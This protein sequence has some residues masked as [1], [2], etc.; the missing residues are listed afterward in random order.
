MS[1][2]I[3]EAKSGTVLAEGEEGA[4]V[5]SLRGQSLLRARGGEPASAPGHG[6]HLHLPL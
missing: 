1:I 4:E 2:V 6:T 5:V 3:R